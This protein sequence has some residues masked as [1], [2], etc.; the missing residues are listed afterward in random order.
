MAGPSVPVQDRVVQHIPVAGPSAPIAG[1]SRSIQGRVGWNSGFQQEFQAGH[2]IQGQDHSLV[3]N[4]NHS[5]IGS[6]QHIIGRQEGYA[7]EE[8]QHASHLADL[9]RQQNDQRQVEMEQNQAYFAELRRQQDDQRRLEAEQHHAHIAEQQQI[10]Q[11][12][13]AEHLQVVINNNQALRNVPKGCHPYE[14]P[15]FRHSLGPMNVSCPNC[16]ALHFQS[17][18]LVNSS[19][20]HPKFGICCLQ[21]QIQLPSISHSPPL[22][23]QLLNSSTPHA[24]NFRDSIVNTI[25]LLLLHLLLWRW[26]MLFSMVVALTH[27]GFTVQCITRWVLYIPK[28]ASSQYMHSYTF[29][30]T[31]L[32]LLHV[33]LGIQTLILSLWQNFSRC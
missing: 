10:L 30:T 6:S 11:Q 32:P 2:N 9:Q 22:L 18:K 31:R 14:D 26:I 27:S 21:G 23:H 20:I 24:R 4:Q 28:M 12:D 16:H 13:A 15:A 8:Y 19:G 17:E 33:T 7:D 29:M 25:L 5:E 3:G 1:P